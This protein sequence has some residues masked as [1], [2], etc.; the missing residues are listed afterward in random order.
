MSGFEPQ[1]T[2][3]PESPSWL[4]QFSSPPDAAYPWVYSFWMEGN[5]SKEGIT[6]DLEG[7]KQA[8]IRGLIFMDGS[9]G[10]PVGPHRFMSESW[11]ELFHHM[12][13]EA[14]RLGLEVNVNND[15]GWAGSGGPWVN[16]NWPPRRS[17]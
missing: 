12:L 2:S 10:N 4:D 8:G 11:L 17:L 3:A 15:P 1:G 9:L 5:I 14:D 16:P 6:A 13:A 7:M